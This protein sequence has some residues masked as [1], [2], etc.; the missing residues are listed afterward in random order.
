ME[1]LTAL[2]AGFLHAEDA[3]RH[4]SLAIGALAVLEGPAPEFDAVMSAFAQRMTACP[5]LR[6]RL[7]MR[8]FDIGPPE[9][10]DDLRF[11]LAHHVR[12]IA[13]PRPGDDTALHE[14]VA[15][16]MATRLDRDRPLWEIWL[17][18]GLADDRWAMLTKIHRC[19]ADGSSAMHMIAGLCD[20][21]IQKSFPAETQKSPMNPPP[22]QRVNLLT[23]LWNGVAAVTASL[24]G[25]VDPSRSANLNGPVGTQRR[26][27]TGRVALADVETICAAF[28]VTIDDVALAAVTESYRS[29]LTR[30]GVTPESHSLRTLVPMTDDRA[31]LMLPYLPVDE[32]NPLRRLR[33]VH[34]Q[35]QGAN[36]SGTVISVANRLP[37]A[38]TARLARILARA[39]QRAVVTAAT[40]ISG[41]RRPLRL[42]GHKVVAVYPVPPI[43]MQLR[44]GVA[45]LSYAD[46]L[47]F[48]ILT[49]F[50]SVPEADELARGVEHAVARLARVGKRRDRTTRRRGLTLVHSA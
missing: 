46:Q 1:R 26:Y 47:Y 42:M 4:V 49:D 33:A 11:D 41:P 50:D 45:M 10:V 44:T 7:R 22:A 40:N 27:S 30:R 39:P 15:G 21:G 35:L 13:L 34:S 20:G 23:G 16:L 36:S 29:M 31:S 25:V 43:A 14:V 19:M 17:I 2:D 18:E 12:R 38:V 37:F 28:D 32:E 24:A 3:D 48:G 6:Q 8:S 5:R 9:W